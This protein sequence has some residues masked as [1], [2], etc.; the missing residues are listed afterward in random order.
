MFWIDLLLVI[1]IALILSSLL[2]WGLGWRHPAGDGALGA[3]FLFL[4]LIILF[5]MWA[6]GAWIRPW[7]PVGYSTTWLGLL[8]IGAFVALLI[9]AVA[10][11]T[12]RPP[13]L[14]EARVQVQEETTMAAVF[15][16]FFWI[17]IVGLV[18]TAAVSYFI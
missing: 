15:G 5:A 11:P 16:L 10:A 6:G 7:G 13:T 12:R 2:S 4:F 14:S 18:I 17:L 8:L 3:S 1:F 9:A